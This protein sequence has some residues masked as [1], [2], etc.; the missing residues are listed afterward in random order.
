MKPITHAAAVALIDSDG[1]ILIQKRKADNEIM[2]NYWEFPGGKIEVGETPE[3]CLIR[4]VK[5]ELGVALGCR[6]PLSFISEDRGEYH[7]IVYLY[8]SRDTEGIPFGAEGQ[9]IKWVR[10][11]ELSK[12]DLLPANKALIPMI[13]DYS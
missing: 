6:A 8:I 11:M 5:E 4:E 9:E 3:T 1:R 12:Y 13:R 2:P 10:P 7:I